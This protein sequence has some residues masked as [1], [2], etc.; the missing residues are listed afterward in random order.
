MHRHWHHTSTDTPLLGPED[1][2]RAR[3]TH[4]SKTVDVELLPQSDSIAS[5]AE[6]FQS[7][8][9][10]KHVVEVTQRQEEHEVMVKQ[11]YQDDK[12]Q[13]QHLVCHSL[14]AYNK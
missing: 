4:A 12:K 9:T 3:Y 10:V 13:E 6:L 5:S 11:D 1:F 2:E 8:S 14:I 7:D